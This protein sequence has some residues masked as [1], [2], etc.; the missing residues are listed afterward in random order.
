MKDL[1]EWIEREGA[2]RRR[3]KEV[4]KKEREKVKERAQRLRESAYDRLGA[5]GAPASI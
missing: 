3:R 4:E 2:E 1:Q 5:F